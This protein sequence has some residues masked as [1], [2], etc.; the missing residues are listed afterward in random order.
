MCL[1]Y[2]AKQSC[3]VHVKIDWSVRRVTLQT[4]VPGT[5]ASWRLASGAGS[6]AQQDAK[7]CLPSIAAMTHL[8]SCLQPQIHKLLPLW[9]PPGYLAC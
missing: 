5:D 8:M 3:A 9:G 7:L 1:R 2:I 4:Q 6:R